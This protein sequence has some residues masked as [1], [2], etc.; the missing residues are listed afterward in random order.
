MNQYELDMKKEKLAAKQSKKN[1]KLAEVANFEEAETSL[2][3]SS[4]STTLSTTSEHAK[5]PPK[6]KKK[7]ESYD[8]ELRAFWLPSVIIIIIMHHIFVVVFLYSTLSLLIILCI[9]IIV[10]SWRLLQ[11]RASLRSLPSTANVPKA[12]KH[13]SG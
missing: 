4:R 1:A 12:M 3:P 8:P 11:S 10:H 13:S 7:T 5:E 9:I 6:K 2:L